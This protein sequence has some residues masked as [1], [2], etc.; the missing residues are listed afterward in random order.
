MKCQVIPLGGS[1]EAISETKQI[2][3]E[4]CIQSV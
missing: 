1:A 4:S 2:V 3:R